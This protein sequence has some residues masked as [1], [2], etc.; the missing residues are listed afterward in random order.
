MAS[1]FAQIPKTNL[2]IILSPSSEGQSSGKQE[3]PVQL[4][5]FFKHL[6]FSEPVPHLANGDYFTGLRRL[7]LS[8]AWFS[9][10]EL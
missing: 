8:T 5:F 9:S 1:E 6:Y 2:E 10:P 7:E 4:F 3:I